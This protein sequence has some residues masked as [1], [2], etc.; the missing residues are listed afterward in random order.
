MINIYD[1]FFKNG[2]NP[3]NDFIIRDPDEYNPTFSFMDENSPAEVEPKKIKTIHI[4]DATIK[5]HHNRHNQNVEQHNEKLNRF[6]TL[7]KQCPTQT[8]RDSR[9]SDDE[10]S[11]N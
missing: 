5:P 4:P 10:E 1:H 8:I 11:E 3:S 6:R 9:E 7:R 2:N